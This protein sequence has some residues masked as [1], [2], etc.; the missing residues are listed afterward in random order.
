[1]ERYK[2]EHI[3]RCFKNEYPLALT[4]MMKRV[5]SLTDRFGALVVTRGRPD[6]AVPRNAILIKPYENT[7]V[8]FRVFI[9][10]LSFNE[11]ID[12]ITRDETLL[13]EIAE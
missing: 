7:V 1:M 5:F 4:T 3:Y 11:V 6:M 10:C 8:V 2:R 9:K 13:C 12:N